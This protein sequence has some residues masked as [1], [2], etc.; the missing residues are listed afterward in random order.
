V[1]TFPFGNARMQRT[2]RA[3]LISV[4]ELDF[5]WRGFFTEKADVQRITKL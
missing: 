1:D 4:C 2:I 3:R 5:D